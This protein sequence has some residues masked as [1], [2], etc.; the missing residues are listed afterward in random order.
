MLTEPL[1]LVQPKLSPGPQR[2]WRRLCSGPGLWLLTQLPLLQLSHSVLSSPQSGAPSPATRCS[3]GTGPPHTHSPS[4]FPSSST[5]SI[6]LAVSFFT[7][8]SENWAWPGPCLSRLFCA[9]STSLTTG[10]AFHSRPGCGV[11]FSPC[12]EGVQT[13]G[14]MSCRWPATPP[15]S[16]LY[17]SRSAHGGRKV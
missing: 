7:E 9:T 13:T 5:Q 17:S 4:P 1:P 8:S 10:H 16:R 2:L 15:G 3:T 6:P 11:L 14:R 12:S